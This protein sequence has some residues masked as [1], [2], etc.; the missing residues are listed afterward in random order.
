MPEGS[1]AAMTTA[2]DRPSSV[3]LCQTSAVD[4]LTTSVLTAGGDGRSTLNRPFGSTK[5][6]HVPSSAATIEGEVVVVVAGPTV[7]TEYE[8]EDC[9]ALPPRNV[10]AIRRTR[11]V[12]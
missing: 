4:P 3:S 5:W 6:T 12:P 11:M 9:F 1:A 8:A 7:V 2:A 10:T